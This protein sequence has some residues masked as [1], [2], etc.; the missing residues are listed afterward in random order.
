MHTCTLTIV[1][2]IHINLFY[3]FRHTQILYNLQC[4]DIWSDILIIVSVYSGIFATAN[5]ISFV[6]VFS[7]R[8]CALRGT[9]VLG[10]KSV[11]CDF[12]LGAGTSGWVIF[13]FVGSS[14]VVK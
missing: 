8:V 5:S 12:L 10:T 9:L 3:I 13:L 14:G 7:D 2:T 6:H 1:C 4:Q 11:Q